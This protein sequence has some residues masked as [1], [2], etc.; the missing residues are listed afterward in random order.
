MHGEPP[1]AYTGKS[2]RAFV[3]KDKR[4]AQAVSR[5]VLELLFKHSLIN[6]NLFVVSGISRF[7]LRLVIYRFNLN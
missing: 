7:G 6:N 4:D 5:V 1:K 2:G 3:V